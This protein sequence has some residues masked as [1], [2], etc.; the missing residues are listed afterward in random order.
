MRDSG[1][2]FKHKGQSIQLTYEKYEDDTISLS[3]YYKNTRINELFEKNSV[4]REISQCICELIDEIGEDKYSIFSEKRNELMEIRRKNIIFNSKVYTIQI[5]ENFVS[6]CITR[7]YV[8]IPMKD[9]KIISATPTIN[10]D[11]ENKYVMI[12]HLKTQV[13]NYHK[14]FDIAPHD[15]FFNDELTIKYKE[16]SKWIKENINPKYY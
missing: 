9:K 7:Y 15:D 10:K 11:S 8:Y 3:F 13:E 1:L 5:E 14:Q 12:N 4:W 16:L 6:D 2:D